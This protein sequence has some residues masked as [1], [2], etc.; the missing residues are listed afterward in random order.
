MA[1]YKELIRRAIEALPENNGAAR[2]GV[3]E[4]ARAALVNQ[5]R[6]INPPLPARDITQ[7]RL[8]LEDCIRQVEQ[9]ATD[10]MLSGLK[11]G[12]DRTPRLPPRPQ[13]Q[14]PRVT[15][16]AAPQPPAVRPANDHAPVPIAPPAKKAAEP[17]KLVETR[18]KPKPAPGSIEEIIAEA[19]RASDEAENKPVAPPQPEP[20]PRQPAPVQQRPEPEPVRE[21][22]VE[23]RAPKPE[24]RLVAAFPSRSE[25]NKPAAVPPPAPEPVAQPKPAAA[26]RDPMTVPKPA[27]PFR[28]RPVE[29]K[30][31]AAAVETV[32]AVI[33]DDLRPTGT[34][35]APRA[36]LARPMFTPRQMAAEAIDYEDEAVAPALSSVREVEVEDRHPQY[37]PE[38]NAQDAIDRAIAALDREARGEPVDEEFDPYTAPLAPEPQLAPAQRNGFDAASLKKQAFAAVG[39]KDGGPAPKRETQ[40]EAPPFVAP[41]ADDE[42]EDEAPLIGRRDSAIPPAKR[43]RSIFSRG[44]K[45]ERKPS[46]REKVAK[47]RRGSGTALDASF[48]R[49]AMEAERGSNALTIFLLVA[50]FLLVGAGGGA[51]WAWREGYLNLDSMFGGGPAVVEQ[52]ST[53]A[54]TQRAPAAQVAAN[55]EPQA[56]TGGPLMPATPSTTAPTAAAADLK[57]EERLGAVTNPAAGTA[58]EAVSPP[59]LD[60]PG[61]AS[62]DRLPFAQPPAPGAQALATPQVPGAGVQLGSQS[63]LLEASD[64]GRTGAV[65]FSG[66]VDWSR[67]TDEAGEP[68]LVG[69]ASIP[70][71]NLTVDVLIRKN[72]DPGLPASHLME[73]NFGVSDTFVGGAIAGLPGVLLKNEELVQ[74]TPLVGASARIVGNSFL[75]AL[76]SASADLNTNAGL[77]TSRKWMDLAIIYATGK[78]A[79]ITLE[80]D[81]SAQS[82]FADVFQAWGTPTTASTN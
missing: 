48:P 47:A 25:R 7:H 60:L 34:D 72:S 12:E 49:S 41:V 53:A 43:E 70:A 39:R 62:Q 17:V 58:L 38:D 20:A 36:E 33:E 57:T 74:G 21:A 13:P 6:A 28:P 71:R 66:T 54:S 40:R 35:A 64:D 81:D 65:P 78:R 27:D 80:K 68:T 79:I 42:D 69:K 31:A 19:Q 4:K 61:A 37:E 77:L 73:V 23:A 15:R 1:D 9:E 24:P 32:R 18:A 44:D 63:L 22:P 46:K 75:F 67:G 11:Q 10:Q 52:A 59:S 30:R 26:R 5:L 2:R 82:L 14:P 8:N 50:A 29:P 76:S 45:P 3:Y 55:A 56:A 16:E 51:F